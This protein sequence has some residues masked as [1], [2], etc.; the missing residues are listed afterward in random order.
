MIIV[1]QLAWQECENWQKRSLK[2]TLSYLIISTCLLTNIVKGQPTFPIKILNTHD[3]FSSCFLFHIMRCHFRET[4][5][6]NKL[7]QDPEKIDTEES[8]SPYNAYQ[9]SELAGRNIP[10]ILKVYARD[11]RS[12]LI[13]LRRA[14][15]W[16]F[17]KCKDNHAFSML[18]SPSPC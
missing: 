3:G 4:L 2:K 5:A 13:G 17:H 6:L 8:N 14:V 16:C 10:L 1:V 11:K 18:K 15:V 9:K 12:T 7:S